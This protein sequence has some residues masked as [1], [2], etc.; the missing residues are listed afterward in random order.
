MAK[1]QPTLRT[2]TATNTQGICVV[3]FVAGPRGYVWIGEGTR[4]IG[5]CGLAAL[6]R[7]VSSCEKAQRKERRNA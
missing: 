4:A 5:F 1:R 6:K 3:E 2:T 7:F